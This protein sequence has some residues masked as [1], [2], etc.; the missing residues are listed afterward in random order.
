[1]KRSLLIAIMTAS[2]ALMAQNIAVKGEL[3][4][5]MNG[6]PIRN[7]VVLI[8]NGKIES[9]GAA[10][11]VNIPSGF[12]TRT[13]KVVTPGLIDAHTVVGLSGYLNQ[14]QDQDQLEKSGPIQPELR[15]LDAYNPQERLITW[16]RSYGITMMNTGHGP[17]AVISG[18][19]M[20]VKTVGNTV[21]EA[22]VVPE[23][24]IAS[25]LGEEGVRTGGTPGTRAKAVALLRAELVKAQ[26]AV[27]KETAPKDSAPKD[28][29]A[30]KDEAKKP[31]TDIRAE[32]FKQLIR[33]EVPLLVTVHRA[34]DIMTA[35][36][37]AKEFN[38]R[39]ILDGAAEAHQLI[40]EIKASGYPVILHA[41]MYRANGDTA[42]LAMDTAAK[43]QA[44]GIPFAIQSGYE[45]YVPKTRVILWEAAAAASKGL[46]AEDAL[47]AITINAAKILG[48]EARA[49]S[50]EA[51]KDGDLALYDGDPLEWLSHCTGTIINGKVVSNGEEH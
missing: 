48:I 7:G 9:V 6:G 35:M 15:A 24:M 14:P 3:I 34:N 2:G 23:A 22:L 40:P 33:R 42:N 19:T 36:R 1:M 29:A 12:E 11:A 46:K 49:G 38:L 28:A 13:A 50:I 43:L 31:G 25:S 27:Q 4:Y 10:A 17:G 45:G 8:R 21:E 16:V 18:Q 39:L 37:V 20:V 44:A 51:G 30:K 5:T 41:T 26:E 32:V 47:A